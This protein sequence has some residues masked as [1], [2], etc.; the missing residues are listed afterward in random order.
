MMELLQN[1]WLWGGLAVVVA[2]AAAALLFSRAKRKQPMSLD[3][4]K[5]L[6]HL[7]REWLEANFF[8]IASKSGKPRGLSW[9]DVVFAHEVAFARDRKTGRLRALVAVTIHFA[10][11][12]GGGMEDNPNVSNPRAATAVFLLDGDAW[13]TDGKA[14][15]NLDPA[16]TILHYKE[17]LEPAE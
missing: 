10:A 14:V 1:G 5:R 16:G 13:A 12:E 9:T 11:V 6:F 4:A 8:T 17:E 7:R 3:K 2:L 15:M